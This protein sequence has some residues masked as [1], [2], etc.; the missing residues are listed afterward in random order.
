MITEKKLKH[1][2]L[3]AWLRENRSDDLEYLGEKN[4][5]YWYRIGTHK[6]TSGQFKDIELVDEV[7]Q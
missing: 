3:Q 7:E 4:G 5:E 6:I 2:R 1:Y